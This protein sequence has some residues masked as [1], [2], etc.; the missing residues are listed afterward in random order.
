MTTKLPFQ[1][2]FALATQTGM[3]A[4]NMQVARCSRLTVMSVPFNGAHPR[5]YLQASSPSLP[6]TAT[7][8][9]P[10]LDPSTLIAISH[11]IKRFR[12]QPIFDHSNLGEFRYILQSIKQKNTVCHRYMCRAHRVSNGGCTGAPN[13]ATKEQAAIAL[14]APS[15]PSTKES[16][17]RTT[18][19]TTATWLFQSPM[20]RTLPQTLK[21][22]HR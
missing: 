2:R 22:C 19:V 16:L 6:P 4:G 1:S 3:H 11:A 18:L 5:V 10:T 21:S 8:P 17:E 15:L 9:G 7:F 14:T 13:H 12:N 20:K